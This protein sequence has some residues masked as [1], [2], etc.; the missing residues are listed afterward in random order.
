MILIDRSRVLSYQRC[1]RRRYWEYHAF[2]TGIQRKAKSL[3]L[4]FGSAFH[5]GSELMLRGD[6]EGAILRA[7]LFLSNIFADHGVSFDREEMSDVEKAALYGAEEQSAL[8]EAL[9]RGWWA[10]EGESLLEG[11]E[12][13]EVEREGR[14]T[15]T[16]AKPY[17]PEWQD[18]G[19]GRAAPAVLAQEEMVLLFRPDALVRE[20]S[21]GD[22]YVISWK[23][24]AT[25]GVK[26]VREA[27]VDMQSCSETWGREQAGDVK[28]EGTL[29]KFAT[30]GKRMQ[31]DWDNL[32]KQDSF[33]IYGWKKL[34]RDG[35]E[36]WSWTYRWSDPM[37]INPKTGKP[38]GHTLGKGWQK[39]PIWREY[40]GGVKAWI[41]GLAANQIFPRHTSALAA[42]FPSALPV[43]RRPDEIERWKRQ[44]VAQE[45]KVA[46]DV[47]RVAD[48][49][50]MD[51]QAELLDELFPQYTSSCEDYS[52]CPMHAVCWTPAVGQDPVGSGLYTIRT[53]TNHPEHGG[54][55]E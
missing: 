42:A 35:D 1:P 32:W 51:I 29:Y 49:R 48:E 25:F 15:L 31:D 40:P 45:L 37:E 50:N 27:K 13:L 14:A 23:T 20:R 55:D 4:V 44:I 43:S 30:K 41:E 19:G 33:L 8:A 34:A 12:V 26:T 2:G 28:I 52:G 36:N 18:M 10:Y 54:G 17:E 53:V 11:F 16:P 38:V 5:E 47:E 46:R 6:V 24:C 22:L 39:V 21:T 3:P 7:Q 9:L